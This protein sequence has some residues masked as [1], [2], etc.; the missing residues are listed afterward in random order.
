MGAATFRDSGTGKSAKEVFHELKEE[1]AYEFGHGGYTG[2]IAEKHSFREFTP[3]KGMSVQEFINAIED[4][5]DEE[6]NKDVP[7]EVKRAWAVY[8][9]KWGPA[10]CVKDGDRYIFFGWASE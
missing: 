8:D 6:D 4:Y 1:A 10:V 5:D 3:P 2:T 9:D 7:S